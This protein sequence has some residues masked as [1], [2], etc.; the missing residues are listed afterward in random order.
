MDKL[1]EIMA[2]KRRS[3]KGRVRPVR[4]QELARLGQM[5]KQGGSFLQA[6]ARK[7]RLSVIAEIKRKS[8]SAG[9]LAAATSM[10]LSRPANT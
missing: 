3:L 2:A 5:Q 4:E 7:E 8:P 9:E 10:P 6:L 1:A